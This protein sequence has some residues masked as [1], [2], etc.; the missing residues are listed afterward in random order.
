MRRP[1]CP[2]NIVVAAAGPFRFTRMPR[3]AGNSL[4][5]YAVLIPSWEGHYEYVVLASLVGILMVW[6]GVTSSPGR[7]WP[8]LAIRTTPLVSEYCLITLC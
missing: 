7:P 4:C 8:V 6:G 5:G 1:Q 3:M 2:I